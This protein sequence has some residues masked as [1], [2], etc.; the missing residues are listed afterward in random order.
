ANLIFNSKAGLI[1]I[2]K[3]RKKKKMAG[4]GSKNEP[5]KDSGTSMTF[6]CPVLNSTNYTI[7]AVKTKALFNV[8]GICLTSAKEIWEALNVRHVGIERFKE[9]CIQTIETEFESI[10]IGANEPLDVYAGKIT[11]IEQFADLNTMSFQEAVGRLK[12]IEECTKKQT[13]EEDKT[14]KLLF[15]KED[16]KD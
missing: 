2:G 8:H 1:K 10:K 13:N 9:A 7:W 16:A 3:G 12:A 15:T 14:S 11:A 5:T 6:Q 4:D